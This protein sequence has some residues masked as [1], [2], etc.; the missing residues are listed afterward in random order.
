MTK[1]LKYFFY[2]WAAVTVLI[3]MY[4]IITNPDY[5]FEIAAGISIIC[6]LTNLIVVKEAIEAERKNKQSSKR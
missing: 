6:I 4:A 5:K 2:C 3:A 1:R